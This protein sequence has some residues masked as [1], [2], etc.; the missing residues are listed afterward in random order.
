MRSR[1]RLRY[2]GDDCTNV[3]KPTFSGITEPNAT[4]RL[5]FDNK[6]TSIFEATADEKGEWTIQVDTEL[7]DGLHD[8]VI[9]AI[10]NIKG[11]KGQVSGQLVIDTLAPDYLIGGVVDP[12]DSSTKQNILTSMTRPTFAG[13]AEPSTYLEITVGQEIYTNILVD[14]QGEWSFTLTE[15]L[16]DGTHDYH[17]RVTDIAGNLGAD[18]L[19]GKI[20]VDTQAPEILGG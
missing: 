18:N 13:I 6:V 2:S 1:F 16:I 19:T 15:P 17:I 14:K 3:N 20:T 12:T 8:Y 11:I 7:S 10:D 4:I 5:V 9:F